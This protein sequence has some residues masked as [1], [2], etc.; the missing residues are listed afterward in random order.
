MSYYFNVVKY[1]IID[2]GLGW[3]WY[4]VCD[5]DSFF[6]LVVECYVCFFLVIDYDL[7]VVYLS[8]IN[9]LNFMYNRFLLVVFLEEFYCVINFIICIKLINFNYLYFF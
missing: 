5:R 7:D 2:M 4:E 3:L 6:F 1:Y 9:F 8:K